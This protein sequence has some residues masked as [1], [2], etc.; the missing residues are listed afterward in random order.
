[1]DDQNSRKNRP[2]RKNRTAPAPIE[3]TAPTLKQMLEREQRK[4]LILS[5]VVSL[6]YELRKLEQATTGDPY[7]PPT[8]T[9]KRE[10]HT[11][12]IYNTP[13]DEQTTDHRKPQRR[14]KIN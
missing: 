12:Y 11:N 1:M 13:A 10:T 7:R 9:G 5:C 8:R 14:K 2:R 3:A 4:T 6:L